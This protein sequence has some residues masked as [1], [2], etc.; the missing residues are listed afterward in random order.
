[1]NYYE[2]NED[3]LAIIPI[4]INK[5]KVIEK[6]TEYIIDK[7]AYDIM[8]ESC[9]YYGSSYKGRLNASKNI[10]NC[11][12]KLPVLIEETKNLIFFPTKSTLLEECSWINF[13]FVKKI[14]K[15]ENKSIV[16]FTNNKREIFD[17]S[18]LSIENQISR[19]TRL[20]YI[21]Q[22]RINSMKN[23]L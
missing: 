2:I 3:T 14:E 7:K 21:I 10:L 15:L 22:K 12:Y 9:M 13:N 4:D 16:Y 11:S 18:K 19:A 23:N 1:M 17:I 6:E 20:G 5:T 8:D